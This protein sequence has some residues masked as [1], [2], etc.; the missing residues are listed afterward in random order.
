M[1][2]NEFNDLQMV[3]GAQYVGSMLHCAG[4]PSRISPL[5]SQTSNCLQHWPATSTVQGSMSIDVEFSEDV[6][7]TE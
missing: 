3:F 4:N 7:L 1:S 5:H 6:T 2:W